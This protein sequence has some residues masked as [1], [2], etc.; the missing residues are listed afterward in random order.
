MTFK[1]IFLSQIKEIGRSNSKHEAA[2][3]YFTLNPIIRIIIYIEKNFF[4]KIS[5][6]PVWISKSHW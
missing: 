4:Y 1:S 3:S 2:L 6:Y 5:N